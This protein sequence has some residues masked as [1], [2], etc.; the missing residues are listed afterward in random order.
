MK[1]QV[2]DY[3]NRKG[4]SLEKAEKWLQPNLAY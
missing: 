3:A 4:I 2:N 1:D